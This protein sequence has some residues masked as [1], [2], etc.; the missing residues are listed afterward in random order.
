MA[1][2]TMSVSN[3]PHKGLDRARHPRVVT[4]DGFCV[5]R[6]EAVFGKVEVIREGSGI[7]RASNRNT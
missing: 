5:H 1:L 2:Q 3:A 4:V 6:V 7:G